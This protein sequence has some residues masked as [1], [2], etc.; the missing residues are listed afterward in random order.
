MQVFSLNCKGRLVT[1]NQP[2]VMG[3][4]NVTPDSFYTGSRVKNNEALLKKAEAMISDGATILDVGGQSTRPGSDRVSAEEEASRVVPAIELLHKNFPHQLISVDTFYSTVAKEAIKAGAHIVND[5]SAGTIDGDLLSTVAALK[6]PYVLM[7]MRG[8]PQTMQQQAQYKNVTLDVFDALSFKIKEL[9]KA[10][11][12][13]VI[14]DP[15]FGFAKTTAH[16]FQLLR[17][18]SFFKQLGKPLM[19]GLSRKGT[20]YKT[21]QITA[22]KALNGTT[23]V[24]T[25]A[26]LNGANVL[27]V[28]DAKEAKEAVDLYLAYKSERA[29]P[30]HS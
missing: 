13:D 19:V 1:I 17:E 22:D 7:H 4:L 18:L 21:L 12:N 14:I 25:M 3:I 15:G 16:N 8:D 27:R 6:V 9:E 24:H 20:V 28:H 2:V 11:I 23:V 10:G 29:V 26:L 30:D 5:V